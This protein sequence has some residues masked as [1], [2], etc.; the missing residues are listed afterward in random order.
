MSYEEDKYNKFI[1]KIDADVVD[2]ED[3]VTSGNS[4]SLLVNEQKKY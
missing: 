3:S 1:K 2:I 4:T